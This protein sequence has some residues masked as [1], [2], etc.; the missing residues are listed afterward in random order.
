VDNTAPGP[1]PTVPLAQVGG[2]SLAAPAGTRCAGTAPPPLP[3]RDSLPAA[4]TGDAAKLGGCV[5]QSRGHKTRVSDADTMGGES[6]TGSQQAGG[7]RSGAS[8]PAVGTAAAVV[9]DPPTT[10]Y[11]APPRTSTL[12]CDM[13]G[14]SGAVA[15]PPSK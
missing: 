9:V 4:Q 13:V 2:V 14:A 8:S 12:T 5:A 15:P 3:L 11:R 1:L 10:S 7:P 6:P